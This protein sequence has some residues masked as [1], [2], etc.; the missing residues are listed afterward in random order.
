MYPELLLSPNS[1]SY[2]FPVFRVLP[3]F[4]FLSTVTTTT[5][6]QAT[7]I[8]C[9]ALVKVP[10]HPWGS[11]CFLSIPL[12]SILHTAKWYA[13]QNL[14]LC[15]FRSIHNSFPY[16]HKNLNSNAL[17]WTWPCLPPL[18]HS[19]HSSFQGRHPTSSYSPHV[20]TSHIGPSQPSGTLHMTLPPGGCLPGL[21]HPTLRP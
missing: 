5:L 8:S 2:K 18:P 9:A 16:S 12:Q 14:R 6:V 4:L 10:S 13:D 1:L 20:P 17:W 19:Y 21:Q 3:S 7:S 15:T 11:L